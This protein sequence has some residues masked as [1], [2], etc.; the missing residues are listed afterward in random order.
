MA[1]L[2]TLILGAGASYT[3]GYPTGAALRTEILKL[4]SDLDGFS[5][6]AHVGH[7]TIREFLSRF[8][9]SSALSI[10]TF[11][12]RNPAFDEVGKAAIAYVLF[13]HEHLD[14]LHADDLEASDRDNWY[15]YLVNTLAR[16]DDWNAFD[17][18]WLTIVTFNYD[19][20]LEHYLQTSLCNMYGVA[21]ERVRERLQKLR[22]F[23]VYGD[24][25]VDQFDQL[26]YGTPNRDNDR[27]HNAIQHAVKRLKIMKEGRDDNE[28]LGPIRTA[29]QDSTNIAFLG[30]S[31]DKMNVDRLN[32]N[33]NF[34]SDS[35]PKRVVATTLGLTDA[36]V[37]RIKGWLFGKASS[38]SALSSTF[39]SKRCRE[40]LRET[41]ILEH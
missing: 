38:P 10:D 22:I 3:Y 2:T 41:L 30:F 14:A 23:H 29:I 33:E 25:G 16:G 31:F 26:P 15:Q 40:L 18:C 1:G 35:P 34:R 32:Y 5:E 21:A 9:L 28:A 39:L 7:R 12:A 19:R 13:L 6:M 36:E 11:L 37:E 24:L 27:R 17:P 8:R 4:E 20:S